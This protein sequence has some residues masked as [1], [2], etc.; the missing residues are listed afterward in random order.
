MATA[1]KKKRRKPD[2]SKRRLRKLKQRGKKAPKACRKRR[3][4]PKAPAAGPLTGTHNAPARPGDPAAGGSGPVPVV[5][6]PP[7]APRTHTIQTPIAVHDGSFGRREAERLLWRAGFGPRPGDLDALVAM[8]MENAV[9]SLT[10]P[11]GAAPMHGPEPTADGQP[12][13]PNSVYN[14]DHLYWLDRMVRSGHQLVERLA[15]VFHDWW[16]TSNDGVGS[17]RM[18]LAQTN[19]FRSYGLGSFRDMVVAMTQDPA[20]IVWLNAD[21]NR[22]NAVNE[23]YARELMELFTLGADRGAY[24]ETDVRELARSLSGWTYSWSQSDG[25]HDFRWDELNR[26]D[27]THKTVFGKTGRWTWEDA[28]AFVVEHPLH[29]SFFVRKLWSHFVGAPPADEVSA[30]LEQLYVA[31][32]WQIRPVLEAILVSPEFF[33][34]PRMVKPPVVQV[35]G[36]MRAV[37]LPVERAI[38]DWVCA[39]AGQR[40]YQPPDVS[41]WDDDGWLDTATV[42]GRWE[43]VAYVLRAAAKTVPPSNS[44]GPQTAEEALADARGLWGDPW[45]S[46][47]TVANLQSFASTVVPANANGYL[48]SQRLNALRQLVAASPDY[49]TC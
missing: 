16:A 29:A 1:R 41:G 48:R 2:C 8:G 47:D 9:L 3:T 28:C 30:K 17:N 4:P 21:Q 7:P 36:M 44:F 32:G 34:G 45:L 25:A 19:V 6:P 33:A 27:P 26:W 46:D 5:P 12:L 39:N 10:R 13:S 35:A 37:G 38:W 18:M 42:R 15:L 22:K 24:T 31:T 23:N 14:H 40:L 20:M 43:A 49:Q 11:T